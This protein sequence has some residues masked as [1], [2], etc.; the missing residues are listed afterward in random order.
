MLTVKNDYLTGMPVF[1]LPMEFA[2]RES[3]L[4]RENENLVRNISYKKTRSGKGSAKR[5]RQTE[6]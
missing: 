5:D 1:W 6:Y 4:N 2:G 3:I